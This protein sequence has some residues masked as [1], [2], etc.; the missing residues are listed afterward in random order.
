MIEWR[1]NKPLREDKAN[2][3]AQGRRSR[4]HTRSWALNIDKALKEK[5]Q[6]A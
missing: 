6:K 1:L 2:A 4:R 5:A 3:R